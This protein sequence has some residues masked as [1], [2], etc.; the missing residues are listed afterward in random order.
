MFGSSYFSETLA[1][2]GSTPNKTQDDWPDLELVIMS[3]LP[4]MGTAF[5]AFT[6]E[7]QYRIDRECDLTKWERGCVNRELDEYR[8]IVM[9]SFIFAAYFDDEC[10]RRKKST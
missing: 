6:P 10:L 3:A 7:V 2:L 4:A 9:M 1:F 8:R 5:P